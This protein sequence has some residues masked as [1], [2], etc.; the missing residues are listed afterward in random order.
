VLG[1]LSLAMGGNAEP[2]RSGRSAKFDQ[3]RTLMMIGPELKFAI[4]VE[5]YK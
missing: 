3:L 1:E 5:G 4:E 2:R